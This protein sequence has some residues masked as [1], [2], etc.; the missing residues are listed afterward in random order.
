MQNAVKTQSPTATALT[1][2]PAAAAAAAAEIVARHQ[3]GSRSRCRE[4][5]LLLDVQLLQH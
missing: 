3:L 4:A 2:V 5:K 1:H